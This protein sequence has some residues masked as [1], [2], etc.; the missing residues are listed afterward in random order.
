M[1]LIQNTNVGVDAGTLTLAGT[2]IPNGV[3]FNTD[4]RKVGGGTLVAQRFG[5]NDVLGSPQRP[6]GLLEVSGGLLRQQQ[7]PG[8]GPSTLTTSRVNALSIQPFAQLDLTNNAMVIDY[9]GNSPQQD[10]RNALRETRIISSTPNA[11]SVGI[12]FGEQV[13]L[14]SSFPT[15]TPNIFF[16]QSLDSTSLLLR[17]T[18]LGDTNLNGTVD[19]VDLVNLARSF[20]RPG[21]WTNGDSNYDGNVDFIDLVNIA[22]N[23]NRTLGAPGPIGGLDAGGGAS[24]EAE[25]ARALAI[26]PEPTALGSLIGAGF[27]LLRRFR[28]NSDK[29]LSEN[30]LASARVAKYYV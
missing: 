29:L 12:G 3:A 15:T 8:V 17:Y 25:W 5:G 4:F 6:L 21:V 16:G 19:F 26:V 28:R 27:A 9:F 1:F 22:R 11:L 13:D 23:F 20:N 10:V 24:F 14:A 7:N 30:R 18:L 2:I